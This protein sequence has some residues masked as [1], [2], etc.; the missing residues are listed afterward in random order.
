MDEPQAA[1]IKN[2]PLAMK[3][4]P[5]RDTE[6]RTVLKEAINDKVSLIASVF[7]HVVGLKEPIDAFVEYNLP[8]KRQKAVF[9]INGKPSARRKVLSFKVSE[10]ATWADGSNLSEL[11]TVSFTGPCI[12]SFKPVQFSIEAGTLEAPIPSPESTKTCDGTVEILGRKVAPESIAAYRFSCSHRKLEFSSVIK[13]DVRGADLEFLR[14]L[15]P[16][17]NGLDQCA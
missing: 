12:Y 7:K 15:Y 9:H 10:Y 16:T 4:H 13:A 2:R 11:R 1:N 3:R 17:V 8:A 6:I 5:V 14:N